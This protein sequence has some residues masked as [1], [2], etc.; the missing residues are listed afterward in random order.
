M[1]TQFS[2]TSSRD[3]NHEFSNYLNCIFYIFYK[4]NLFVTV[5]Y[6]YI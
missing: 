6:I 3:K 5:N 2:N 1:K 4:L